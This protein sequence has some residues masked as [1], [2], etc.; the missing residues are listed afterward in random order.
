MSL[1]PL[2]AWRIA[3]MPGSGD[4]PLPEP[5]PDG[6]RQDVRSYL[7]RRLPKRRPPRDNGIRIPQRKR[8]AFLDL[9]EGAR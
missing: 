9:R 4:R 2:D 5:L 7:A 1:H 3:P 6:I 8:R